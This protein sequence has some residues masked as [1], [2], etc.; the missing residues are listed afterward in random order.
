MSKFPHISKFKI[1]DNMQNDYAKLVRMRCTQW[2]M[3][4]VVKNC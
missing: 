4:V 1:L 3:M 2:I